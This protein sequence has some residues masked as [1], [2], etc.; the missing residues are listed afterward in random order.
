MDYYLRPFSLAME[1]HG[2]IW[3]NDHDCVVSKPETKVVLDYVTEFTGKMKKSN[4]PHFAFAF[5]TRLTH[6]SVNKAGAGDDLY[7][8]F[9][10]NLDDNGH[11]ENSVLFFFSDHGIRFGPIRETYIGKLEERLPFMFAVFPPW[12]YDKYPHLAANLRTNSHRLTTPFDMYETYKDVLYF[13]GKVPE[14][15]PK[16]RG[17]SLFREIPES[18]TCDDASILPHWCTC[19]TQQAMDVRDD[20]SKIAAKT[21]VDHINFLL[22]DYRHLCEDLTLEKITDARRNLQNDQVLTFKESLN[23]VMGRV[24]HYGNRAK[25]IVD[26]LL[27]VQTSPGQGLFEATVRHSEVQGTFKVMGEISRINIYGEQSSCIE[28]H[29]LKKLCYCK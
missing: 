23:D 7:Y 17:I 25:A 1:D 20:I 2:A 4:K 15:N 11:F 13:T 8:N 10:K 26:Y 14:R 22:A 29:K 21:L 16:S 27:T 24:V 28:A 18:A 19:L 3:R 12:F 9:I 5:I 6:Q